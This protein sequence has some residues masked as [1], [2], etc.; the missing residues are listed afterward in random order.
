MERSIVHMDLDSFFISVERL[1]DASL[2]GKPVIVGGTSDRGVVASCSYEARK[3]GVHSAMPSRMARQ[4]C[5]HAIFIR[6]DMDQYS[7]YSNQVT[8]II[9]GEAPLFEKASIDE[10]YLEITGMDKYIK[11]SMLWT[12]ELRAKIIKETGLPIS[13]GLSKNKTVSKIATGESKPNGERQVDFGTEK[14]F[15]APLSIRKIPGIGDKTNATL[16]KMG[17]SKI[18]TIQS[19]PVLAMQ[20]VL[21]DN[22]SSIWRKANGIDNNPV[23]PYSEQKSMSKETTFD[24]DTTDFEMLK[25]ILVVMVDAL[26]FDLRKQ[27]KVTGCI[28]LKLKYSDFQTHT[29]QASIPYTASDDVLL[30]K[31]TE[32]FLKNYNR[33]VLIRLIGAK[34]SNLVSGFNQINLFDDTEE[35]I[36]L[37]TALDKIRMRFGE[38]AISRAV[39]LKSEK[40]KDDEK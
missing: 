4:L 2:I 17:I 3:F 32:L 36:N 6:G 19:M 21:G 39:G 34:F 31:V 1:M 29:F 5:P 15:L 33:R 13:F 16:Q 27:K 22:G 9:E 7:K 38:D 37:Y 18:E 14:S 12:Q 35:K 28:T 23:E 20:K 10:H 11:H 25:N 24:K 8:E 40:N 30:R 26:A